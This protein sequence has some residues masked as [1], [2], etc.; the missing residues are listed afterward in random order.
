[1]NK[2]KI[3]FLKLNPIAFKFIFGG[4]DYLRQVK[5]KA[6]LRQVMLNL[7]MKM[8]MKMKKNKLKMKHR[9]LG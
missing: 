5:V 1:M 8:K 9:R 3:L 4:K 7:K 2:K 6:S